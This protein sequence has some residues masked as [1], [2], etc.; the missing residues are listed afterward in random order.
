V[1][2]AGEDG[3]VVEREHRQVGELLQLGELDAHGQRHEAEPAV[4]QA[5]YGVADHDAHH[6]RGGRGG[7]GG[8]LGGEVVVVLGLV[9][10]GVGERRDEAV[11]PVYNV[12]AVIV[13]LGVGD[14]DAVDV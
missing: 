4:A 3:L 14:L 9:A 11:E 2:P 10:G 1:S 13:E 6:G 12:S 5:G 7:A 8:Q